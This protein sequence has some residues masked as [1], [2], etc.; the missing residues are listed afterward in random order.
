M[1]VEE[2]LKEELRQEIK[3]EVNQGEMKADQEV[4]PPKHKLE[5]VEQEHM[6]GL[7]QVVKTTVEE[8][9][10]SFFAYFIK[11]PC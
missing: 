1:V 11:E 8:P 4:E 9:T 5:E 7:M 10:Q 2:E 6:R 3:I